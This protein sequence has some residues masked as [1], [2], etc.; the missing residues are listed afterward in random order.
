MIPIFYVAMELVVLTGPDNQEILV[1]PSQ[2]V[3]VR[4]PR[5]HEGHFPEGV[6]CIVHL[7]DGKF[8]TVV[9]PCD[10]VRELLRGEPD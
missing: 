10:V 7:A 6:R 2:V 9:E 4:R 1:Q 5:E 3:T 8:I